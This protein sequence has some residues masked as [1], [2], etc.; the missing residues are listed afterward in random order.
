MWHAV[1]QLRAWIP[2][3]PPSKKARVTAQRKIA[4][5]KLHQHTLNALNAA[6]SSLMP[7]SNASS[8][9]ERQQA[10]VERIAKLWREN[11]ST[12]AT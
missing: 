2:R 9:I 3:E 5:D 11:P 10:M 4:A 6:A 12:T 7:A 8:A 1:E